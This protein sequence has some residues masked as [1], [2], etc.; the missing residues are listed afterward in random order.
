MEMD[1][2]G[3]G[4]GPRLTIECGGGN[5]AEDPALTALQLPG[6]DSALT[7]FK[8][9]AAEPTHFVSLSLPCPDRSDWP[10]SI[11]NSAFM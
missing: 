3:G 11:P 6:L 7:V 4:C 8:K 9:V 2:G 10:A 1:W 5:M